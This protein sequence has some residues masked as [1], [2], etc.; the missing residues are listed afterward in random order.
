M[1]LKSPHYVDPGPSLLR[2]WEFQNPYPV[3]D[4]LRSIAPVQWSEMLGM[5]L[6]FSHE[7]SRTA[8]RQSDQ[9]I[10]EGAQ[11]S[12]WN[13]L[14]S[15]LRAELPTVAYVEETPAL[16]T[17]DGKL[18]LKHRRAVSRP[19]APKSLVAMR[20]RVDDLCAEQSNALRLADQPDLVRD[21][22]TPLAYRVL[23]GIFGVPLSFV[24]IFIEAGE[25]RVR[26]HSYGCNDHEVAFAYEESLVTLK[27]ALGDV[28]ASTDPGDD[29]LVAHMAGLRQAGAFSVDEVFHILRV[30]FTAAQDNLVYSLPLTMMYML[31]IP[32]QRSLV[33]A[34]TANAERAYVEAARIDPHTHGNRRI[35]AF[36]CELGGAQLQAGQGIFALRAAA[37]RDPDAWT[38][39]HIF[40][41]RRDQNEPPGGNLTFGQ[42]PHV[43]MGE[44]LAKL[45]GPA[46]IRRL[47][48]DYPDLAAAPGWQPRFA[49]IPGK[50]RLTALPVRL[51]SDCSR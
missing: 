10:A 50:R 4:E 15:G 5:W 30:F 26:F 44:G 1:S 37:N 24:P 47:F 48:T 12:F 9:F 18:H 42:G 39:P 11:R 13:S 34:D 27:K 31:I 19:L 36:D 41:L 7:H 8:Y 16:Q 23:L 2:G 43:C 29:T 46:G 49:D 6:T 25:A 28:I 3:Y 38:D 45:A 21:Y 14:P 35:V 22:A 33:C 51:F 40:D 20:E 32:S 17:A